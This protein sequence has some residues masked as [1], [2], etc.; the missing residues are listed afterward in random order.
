M[1]KENL[2]R[3]D[4]AE[5]NFLLLGCARQMGEK[6]KWVENKPWD[7]RLQFSAQM[8][9]ENKGKIEKAGED[10]PGRGNIYIYIL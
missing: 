3:K 6:R 10:G 7:P 4:S 1:R 8:C 9:A 5:S 2:D